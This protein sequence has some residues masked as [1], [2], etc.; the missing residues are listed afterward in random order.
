[1]YKI[2]EAKNL[3]L[4]CFVGTWLGLEETFHVGIS[5]KYRKSILNMGSWLDTMYHNCLGGNG[6]IRD[7][8]YRKH[9]KT[10]EG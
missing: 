9:S 6:T 10:I 4:K 5:G 3:S 7:Q 8:K 2:A 1:M